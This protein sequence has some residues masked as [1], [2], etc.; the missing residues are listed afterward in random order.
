[1]KKDIVF[2]FFDGIYKLFV[3]DGFGC[4]CKVL[5]CVVG[6]LKDLGYMICD[7]KM[8]DVSGYQF[9][10]EIM[11]QN[12]DQ[13]KIVLVY[14]CFF[15]VIGVVVFVCSVDDSFYQQCSQ[16]FDFDIIMKFFLFLL[17]LGLEQVNCWG[18]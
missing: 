4:D 17:L 11:M 5:Q 16:F 10:F 15:L 18:F 8:L 2:Q 3:M 14:Q 6:L 7:G 9:F 13:E 1:M 12:F